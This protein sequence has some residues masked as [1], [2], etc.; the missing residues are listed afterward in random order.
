MNLEA[1]I[2]A[3]VDIN[4]YIYHWRIQTDHPFSDCTSALFQFSISKKFRISELHPGI[5]KKLPY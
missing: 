3:Y 4:I 1:I 5:N 2:R